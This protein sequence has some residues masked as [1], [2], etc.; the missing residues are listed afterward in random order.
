MIIRKSLAG[1]RE[2]VYENDMPVFQV[3]ENAK[4]ITLEDVRKD[5][6]E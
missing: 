1:A 6:D 2:V 4:P 3:K 5:G